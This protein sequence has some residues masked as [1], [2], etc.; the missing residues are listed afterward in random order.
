MAQYVQQKGKDLQSSYKT[1]CDPLL[2]R[3]ETMKNQCVCIID[4][5]YGQ[6]CK[7]PSGTESLL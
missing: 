5:G 2:E 1:I 3:F 7:Y 4:G 6:I